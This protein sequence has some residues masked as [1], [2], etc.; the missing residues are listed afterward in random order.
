MCII[1]RLLCDKAK[2]LAYNSSTSLFKMFL[3]PDS[4][5]A[6]C[7]SHDLTPIMSQTCMSCSQTNMRTIYA[8]EYLHG[9]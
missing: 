6:I 5:V 1:G 3:L 2:P 7:V 9:I 4:H 8:H